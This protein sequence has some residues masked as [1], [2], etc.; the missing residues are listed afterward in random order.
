VL[1]RLQQSAFN[2]TSLD[3]IIKQLGPNGT[4]IAKS[5]TNMV[6]TAIPDS[7]WIIELGNWFN[8]M[9]STIQLN[10]ENFVGGPSKQ[11]LQDWLQRPKKENEWMC[12]NKIGQRE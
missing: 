7:Q 9:L 1:S 12:A 11:H 4:R 3:F 6:T 2:G 8:I 5:T 10:V